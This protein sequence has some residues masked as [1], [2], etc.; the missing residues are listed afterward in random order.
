MS[1]ELIKSNI[2]SLILRPTLGGHPSN[3]EYS[4]SKPNI[5]R[6]TR[7]DHSTAMSKIKIKG[8]RRLNAYRATCTSLFE[9]SYILNPFFA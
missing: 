9:R 3:E 6:S 8:N 5:L 2:G 1:M 7:E 4:S